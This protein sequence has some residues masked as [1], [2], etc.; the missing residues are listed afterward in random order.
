MKYNFDQVI[1]RRQTASKK[2]DTLQEH[3]GTDSITP[4][5][6]AD[7]DFLSPA[8][9]IEALRERADQGV[10]GYSIRTDSYLTSI[11]DWFK[12]RYKWSIEKEWISHSPGIV[13]ALSLIIHS[14]TQPGDKVIVQSPVHHAFYRVL[15]LQGREVV[16]NPLRLENGRYTMDFDDLEAKLDS[17]VKMI[18]LCNPHNPVGRVW[19]KEELTKLGEICMKHNILVV[20]DEIH[21]DLV[22]KPHTYVPFAS[23]SEEF[24]NHSITCIAPSKTFNLVGLQTSGII[25]QNADIRT[26]FEGA[27]NAFSLATPNYFGIVAL[28]SAYRHGE[29]WLNQLL[30]YLQGN[31]QLLTEFFHE[32]LPE[33]K[34]IQPEGT[35]LAWLDF[36]DF[37]LDR[38]ELN[39]L[40]LEEAHI[41]FDDGPIF[42]SGGEGFMRMNFACPRSVLEKSLQQLKQ[43]FTLLEKV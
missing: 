30:D 37:N 7:M 20:S 33:I 27:V 9:V 24:A 42:G 17:T 26:K 40:V 2:W 43:A 12:R 1:N 4:M 5:W 14:F 41:G 21:C 35:Y 29:D 34:V 28:E 23:I 18:F 13:P 16:E 36:R 25:I 19:N 6:V 39:Q 22:F 32:H 10:F 31:L 15:K 38:E 11:V 8:P 3:F